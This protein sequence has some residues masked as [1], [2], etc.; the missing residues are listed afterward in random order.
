[1][2]LELSAREAA[3]LA[4]LTLTGATAFDSSSPLTEGIRARFSERFGVAITDADVV[5]V[6][7]KIKFLMSRDE[8]VV[9]DEE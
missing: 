7:S 8:D 2:T 9:I 3:T 5:S 1:M 6:L 4:A